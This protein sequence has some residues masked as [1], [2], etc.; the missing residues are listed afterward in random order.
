MSGRGGPGDGR[1][2]G[3]GRGRLRPGLRPVAENTR[4]SI[5]EQLE[6]FQ[7]SDATG[8]LPGSA[9]GRQQ[10]GTGACCPAWHS[11]S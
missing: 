5:T 3:R 9:S 6:L 1:G 10:A 11:G 4:L 8:E 2:G 7:R